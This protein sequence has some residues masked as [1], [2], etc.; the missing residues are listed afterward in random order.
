MP[1]AAGAVIK[2]HSNAR[3]PKPAVRFGDSGIDDAEVVGDGVVGDGGERVGEV[4]SV[5]RV[6]VSDLNHIITSILNLSS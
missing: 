5:R 4:A 3:I 2:A 1:K 6:A